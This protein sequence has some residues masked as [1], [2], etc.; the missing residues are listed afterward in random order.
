ME[1]KLKDTVDEQVRYPLKDTH[2]DRLKYWHY[3]SVVL[4]TKRFKLINDKTK[5]LARMIM[6]MTPEG[7][8]QSIALSDLE[9]VRMRANAAIEIDECKDR[10]D[11]CG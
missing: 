7:R 8:N 9:S 11:R 3:E 5:E 4:D 1:L 2:R 6:K 10:G